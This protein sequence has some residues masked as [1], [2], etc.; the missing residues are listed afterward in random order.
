MSDHIWASEHLAAYLA[1]GLDGAERERFD[2][3]LAECSECALTLAESRS[4]D[5]SL[6]TLFLA[7]RPKAELEDRMIRAL[8]FQRP[9]RGLSTAIRFAASMAAL[10]VLGVIGAMGS[11]MLADGKLRFPGTSG[12]EAYAL[13][14]LNRLLDFGWK[15]AVDQPPGG[16]LHRWAGASYT[17]N[18]D[19]SQFKE[20]M[21]RVAEG[22]TGSL[23]FGPG[24]DQGP[25]SS[26][27]RLADSERGKKLQDAEKGMEEARQR[28][29][30]QERLYKGG[31]MGSG[32]ATS[33]EEFRSALQQYDEKRKAVEQL[34]NGANVNYVYPPMRGVPTNSSM[35]APPQSLPVPADGQ[36]GTTN[37]PSGN[38]SADDKKSPPDATKAPA[39]PVGVAGQVGAPLNDSSTTRPDNAIASLAVPQGEQKP[40]EQPPEVGRRVIIRSGDIEFEITSFDDAVGIVTRLVGGVQGGFIA[41]VNSEKLPNGK[42]R[43][44]V[45]VRVPPEKLDALVLELRKELTKA[46]ELK[47][48][49]I[50][51]QD[52]TKQYTD[53]ESRL[54]A[55]RAME[56]RLLK[57]IKDG[58]GQI[59]D[60]IA[61]EKELGVWRTKIEEHE[62]E[63]RYYSN[64]VALSTLNITLYEKEMR[65]AASIKETEKVDM[66]IEVEDVEKAHKDALAAI[67]AAK[68]RIGKAEL[69]QAGAGQFTAIIQFEADPESAGPLRD[70]LK[71]LGNVAR[72][73]ID[74]VRQPEGGSGKPS[75]GKVDRVDTHFTVSLYNLIGLIPRETVHL[76]LVAADAEAT[77][78]QMLARAQKA[79]GKIHSAQLNSQRSDMTNGTIQF[80]VKSAEADAVLADLRK[81]GEVMS[82]QVKE[83]PDGQ[84]VTRAKQGFLV[85][86]AALASVPPRETISQDLAMR[87]VPKGFAAIQE[88]IVKAHGRVLNAQL[89]ELDRANV[90]ADL[91]FEVRRT[92]EDTIRRA[93]EAAG[94][95]YS[96][97]VTRVPESDT[98][99]DT[100]VRWR[101]KLINVNAIPP[102]ETVGLGIEVREVEQASAA[103]T[104]YVHEAKG[105]TVDSNLTHDASG[106]IVARLVYDVPLSAA[107][108]VIEKLKSAGTVREQQ[109]RRNPQA[110][111]SELATARIEVTLTNEERIIPKDEGFWTQVRKGLST[112]F[113]AVSWSLIVVIIG[114]CFVLPWAVVIYVAFLIIR[115]MRRSSQTA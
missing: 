85:E 50:G 68:G 97:S 47:S 77:Y 88:T 115:R 54:R 8:R 62:G 25:A 101:V 17:S 73:Q 31:G 107:P 41:T 72:L 1:G 79:T 46:G 60:L 42:V 11:S 74:R 91:D 53:L 16:R 111:E 87:D 52:I 86:V 90:T 44:S 4:L 61:A 66:G 109:V 78:K 40:A 64:L 75:D 51:S 113:V 38:P 7:D 99:I 56:E 63:L 9:R 18:P 23:L 89:N 30:S 12:D 58:T 84:N 65:A 10:L 114:L 45:V 5:R 80:D 24:S 94:D 69:K 59:K 82:L 20:V 71:Q 55:A 103:L 33:K 70:R 3:H 19:D 13:A 81:L 26:V 100:K 57:I 37:K 98:V 34:K 21:S 102:S 92:E 83:N 49:R 2:Q 112:S 95:I 6:E 32:G 67:T 76:K 96:R 93:L 110:R 27:S 39:P 108:G 15:S 14:D 106:K 104:S 48:Q 43:G 36:V 28:Y 22:Q 35:P 29:L 105:R